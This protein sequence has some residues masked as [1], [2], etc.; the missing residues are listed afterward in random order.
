MHVGVK[1]NVQD[2]HRDAAQTIPFRDSSHRVHSWAY[3]PVDA[4]AAAN[5]GAWNWPKP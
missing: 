2:S 4:K 3:A 5:A 1:G